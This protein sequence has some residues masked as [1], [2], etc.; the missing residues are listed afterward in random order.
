MVSSQIKVV[1][2]DYKDY[3]RQL[4]EQ[5]INEIIGKLITVK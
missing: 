3:D 1:E 4:K 2:C 5:F